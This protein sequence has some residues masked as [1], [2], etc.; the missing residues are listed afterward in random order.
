MKKLFTIVLALAAATAAARQKAG[1]PTLNSLRVK[2]PG[3]ITVKADYMSA[4]KQTGEMTATGHVDAVAAPYRFL[5]DSVTRS[6]T[7]LYTMDRAHATTCTNDLC[8]LHW[9]VQGDIRY[10]DK[11]SIVLKDVKLR[12]LGVPVAYLPYWYYPLNTDY[13][14]RVTPGYT[15]R[16]GAYLLTGYVYNLYNENHPDGLGLGGSTYVDFRARNGVALGQTVRWRLGEFG[17]GRFKFY[18]AWDEHHDKYDHSW[19]T[20]KRL[21]SH[22]GS[23][24]DRERYRF[25][26]EH[27]AELTERDSLKLHAQYVS[28]SHFLHDFFRRDE[29]NESIPVNE[30]WYEHRENDYAA[31]ASVGG[32]VNRFYGGTA[33]LPEAW[34]SVQPQPVFDTIVNYEATLRAGYL[35]R[36][37]ARYSTDDLPFAYVPYIGENGRGADYQAFRMDTHHRFTVPFKIEDVVSVVPRAGYRLTYWSN[38]GERDS[39]Y[40]AAS[41]D[42]MY[43]QIAELGATVSA[44]GTAWL[45]DDWRHTLEPYVD[46]TFQAADF[47]RGKSRRAYVFDAFDRSADWL[48]QFGFEGRTL[49]Y[50][51]HGV[52]PGIRNLFQKR[53]SNGILR[54]FLDVDFYAAIPFTDKDGYGRDEGVLKGYAKDWKYGPYSKRSS[55]VPGARVRFTPAKDVTLGA[56]VEYDADNDKFAYADVALKHKVCESFSWHASYI[57]R[58]SRIWDYLAAPEEELANGN[59]DRWNWALSNVVELGFENEPVHFFAWAPYVRWDVRRN[60]LEECGLRFDFLTDCIGYRIA[61]VHEDSYTRIDGS[62]ESS[63]DR[64]MLYL[65]LRALGDSNGLEAARF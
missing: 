63:E 47:S 7:G 31:G 61:Y 57:G 53:D 59:A 50:S 21:Y 29:T 42:D 36:N 19:D 9:S 30:L 8:H 34:L 41:G 49:P 1:K 38:S 20:G 43:R 28:D 10:Q 25:L 12:Y 55:V 6:S 60:D 27:E 48:D 5:A 23:K 26:L 39:G 14:V 32:P 46:Y 45:N 44:R 35:N 33:R 62:R 37:A 13:G 3:D 54:T 2:S 15:S 22:W 51:W 18:H 24:V 40:T 52:R 56:R 4:S 11:E 64:V 58:D 65:Y 17:K 16:W